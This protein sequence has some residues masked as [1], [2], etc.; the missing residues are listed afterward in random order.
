M[1]KIFITILSVFTILAS[2]DVSDSLN[3][4]QKNPSNVPASGLFANGLRNLFD[5]MNSANSNN[6][7]LRL[8]SQYWAQTTYPEESQYNQVTRNI[9]GNNWNAMYRDV[10][11]DLKGAKE[12]LATSN[13][14]DIENKVAIISII[15]VY[16]Y[17]VLVD[18]FGDVPYTQALD[19][20]NPSP[21]YDDAETIYLDLFTKLNAA[22]TALDETGSGFASGQDPVYGGDVSLWKKAA[23]SLKLRMA[24]RLADSNP[25]VSKQMAEAAAA[26][27]ILDNADNFGIA[28]L[29]AAPNT[30][31]L[32]VTLVQSGRDDFVA[33]NTFVDALNPLNDPR[34]PSFFTTIN[35]I[36]DGGIYGDANAASGF[37]SISDLMK[38]PSLPGNIMTAAEVHFLLAEATERGYA[39]GG[40]AEGH[41]NAGVTSSITEWGGTQAEATAY[42]AQG[43]VA[44]GTAAG[45]W[46]QKVGTQK[47]IAMFNNGMEGWTTYRLLD[48]PTLNAPPGMS[49]SDIPTRFLYPVSEATLNGDSYNAAATAIG[50]DTKTTK[51]FFDKN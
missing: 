32:W 27:S 1:K 16:A 50:G 13:E 23:N 24:M 39:V 17:T 49:V 7:V 35:G 22:I 15:E 44:Y 5:Q 3:V 28:Y 2:C 45:D 18:Y 46:K 30:N 37:S 21:A 25:A 47:W 34:L 10:L 9:G 36:Y 8:Y 29:G 51:L 38:D 4:D 26:G 20:L 42:L 6:N 43:S 33:A 41:Y 40:N 19:P 48:Q 31:P 11:Q 12:L 14:D